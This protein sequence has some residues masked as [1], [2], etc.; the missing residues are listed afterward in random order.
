MLKFK[1][2]IF[3]MVFCLHCFTVELLSPQTKFG[4]LLCLHRFL[5]HVLLLLLL[6]LLFFLSFF[7]Q[8][9]SDTFLGDYWTEI[10]DTSQEC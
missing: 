9:L 3:F 5:L 1:A 6:L 4:D 2:L 8:N 7:R 10:N